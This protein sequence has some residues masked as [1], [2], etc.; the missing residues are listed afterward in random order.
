MTKITKSL[1]RRAASL[2]IELE[3]NEALGQFAATYEGHPS[4]AESAKA[5]LSEAAAKRDALL[6]AAEAQDEETEDQTEDQTEGDEPEG[7]E[8]APAPRSVVAE[9]Y[10]REYAARGNADHCGDWLAVTLV[11][12]TKEAKLNLDFFQQIEAANGVV[13]KCLL[14]KPSDVGRY[15]MT[16]RNL[17][18][19]VVVAAGGLKLPENFRDGEFLEAPAEWIAAKTAKKVK[20]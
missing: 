7:D 17:L 2:G 12:L 1:A 3:W 11:G 8:E 4:F 6:L 9:R 14:Q 18:Q 5:A 19:K 10:R 20:A 16:G 15:R 13:N